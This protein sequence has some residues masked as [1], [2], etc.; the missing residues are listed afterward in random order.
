[1]STENVDR[2]DD[3]TPTDDAADTA[4][5]DAAKAEAA[6][7]A[8]A[9]ETA[10]AEAK[11][12]EVKAEPKTEPKTAVVDGD[13]D[14]EGEDEAKKK[15]NKRIPLERHEQLMAKQREA[16]AA[17]AARLAQYEKGAKVADL[18]ADIT[19]ADTK[20]T[21]LEKQYAKLV[22]DGEIEKAAAVMAD[23]RRTEREMSAAQNDMKLAAAV[24]E[25]T[26]RVR[27]ST[28]LE[29]I[30]AAYPQLNPDHEDYD[31]EIDTDVADL[32]ATY[33]RKG[34]TPTAALQKAVAKLVKPATGKQEA[35][36]T[37]TP[38]VDAAAVA[39]ERKKEAVTKTLDAT[40]SGGR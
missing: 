33:E 28:A 27:Y 10:A 8:L 30:E 31:S 19:A 40:A 6:A 39:A 35:A 23:I 13:G 17:L 38:K 21:D 36:T 25:A 29:R 5:A 2:G 4:A 14:G 34:L 20:I 7:A 15:A 3:F 26:E 22:A 11:K 24:A 16:N 32:K 37:V 9:A 18:N 1:M 12:G